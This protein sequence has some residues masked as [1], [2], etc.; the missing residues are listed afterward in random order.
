MVEGNMVVVLVLDCSVYYVVVW[1]SED[2]V[3]GGIGEDVV[4]VMVFI[5]GES[6]FDKNGV[7]NRSVDGNEFLEGRV[8]VW[9]DF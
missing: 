4:L 5:D 8:V 6:I 1:E 2:G 7:E 9:E 3:N